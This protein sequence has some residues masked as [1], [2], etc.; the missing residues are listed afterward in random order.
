MNRTA[1]SYRAK[2]QSL[3]PR[4]MLVI[5]DLDPDRRATHAADAIVCRADRLADALLESGWFAVLPDLIAPELQRALL[6]GA[7]TDG[8]ERTLDIEIEKLSGGDATLPAMTHTDNPIALIIEA[9]HHIQAA[10]RA[11]DAL[12]PCLTDK[13]QFVADITHAAAEGIG[14]LTVPD[15]YQAGAR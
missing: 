6:P 14:K 15:L 3:D 9:H 11:M 13:G 4:P 1:P 10:A 2:R 5:R 7:C 12:R 8:M